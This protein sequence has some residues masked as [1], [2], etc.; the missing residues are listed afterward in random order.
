MINDCRKSLFK[1][2]HG[3]VNDL[4][5]FFD[6]DI[7]V[8]LKAQVIQKNP[9]G[10]KRL[11]FIKGVGCYNIIFH[12]QKVNHFLKIMKETNSDVLNLNDY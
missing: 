10:Y 4:L 5:Q 2:F 8:Q 7:K 1:A 3:E 6:S 11:R 12:K 9:L